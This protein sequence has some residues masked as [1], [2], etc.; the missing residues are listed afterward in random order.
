[1]RGKQEKGLKNLGWAAIASHLPGR[2]DN[3]VKNFWNSHLRK[4]FSNK[5]PS[6][7][8]KPVDTKSDS[9]LTRHMVQW[10]SVRVEAESRLSNKPLPLN[11]PSDSKS[12]GDYFLNLWNSKVGQSFRNINDS[13]NNESHGV[14]SHS[15][16]SQT[17]SLTKVESCKKTSS[18]EIADQKMETWNCKK[19]SK[20]VA[21][22]YS[23]NT[24]KSYE[25]DDSSD[26]MMK[27]LLDFPVGDN[28]MGFLEGIIDDGVTTYVGD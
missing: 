14:A 25:M 21:A 20:D 13:A 16:T 7:S 8:S 9:P 19:E 27:L 2:T 1:M 26:A 5:A 11:A 17:S 28:D 3:D 23:D 12:Q 22:V 24:S 10:E 6:S 4:R 18:P 15:P